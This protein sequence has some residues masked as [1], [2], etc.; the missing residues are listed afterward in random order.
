MCGIVGILNLNHSS[1]L[2]MRAEPAPD[3]IQEATLRQ[4]LAM[5]R[6]RGPDQFGIYLDDQVGLGNARLSIIDLSSGQQPIS[7]EDGT[8]WIVFN[9]EIFNYVE[10]RPQLIARGHQFSTNTDTEVILHLYEDFGPDCLAHL[11]GQFAF[12]IWDTRQQTLFLARDRLG[13]RP[14]FYTLAGDTL[15]FG[16]E[17]KALLAAP[18]VKAELDPVALDQIFTFWSTLSPRTAFRNIWDVPPGHYLLAHQGRVTTER[19]W[20][21]NFP[22][23]EDSETS[24]SQQKL[25]DYLAEFRALLVDATQ[26]RLRADVPVGAY[27]SGGLDSSTTAAIIRNHTN[28]RLD[29][30]SIAFSDPEF[31]ESQYQRQMADFLKTDHQVVYA[32]H[33]DIG[34]VFPEVI[35]HTE[36]PLLRTSPA[37]LYLLSKL[38]RERHFKV[39]LTGEGADEF[40]AGYNIF[41]EAR[42]RRF[43]AKQPES[44]LR[45][46]L[47]KRLY[48]YISDLSSG[49][50]SYLAAFFQQGLTE[51]DTLDY[52]HAIRWRNT[53]RTKRFFSDDFHRLLET[54]TMPTIPYPANFTRWDPLHRAQYLE[55][56]IFLSQ[57]LLSSQGDRVAMANSVEG[58]FP[59]LDYRVVEFCNRLPPNLKL[60]NLNEKYLLKQ[61]AREWLP[62]EIWQRPKRPYRAP[63]HRSFFND[64]TPDYVRELLSAEQVKASGLFKPTAVSQLTEKLDRGMR[65]SET[66]DM[67]L[68]GILSSQ[69]VYRQFVTNFEM[70]PPLSETDDVKVCIGQRVVQGV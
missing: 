47:L 2:P 54:E 39:V 31:D 68:A 23:R 60:R 52:S 12:A 15:I 19:Y 32:T 57:Y 9:G 18:G 22:T 13:I 38:V 5:I 1:A 14:L 59:F 37:P 45:P 55:I 65:L 48:R 44:K 35:W 10:L 62:D 40:L 51:V 28:N 29:T 69:L 43:W 46:L 53:S 17:I 25:E 50:E 21:V 27:L 7:N 3:P 41:K 24:A 67:A 64:S 16:S 34:H 33:A 11:N 42:V 30:F 66:D 58:R 56:S 61:L 4:M 6:H 63:I 8:L 20:A 36:I 26:I 70:P 49:N